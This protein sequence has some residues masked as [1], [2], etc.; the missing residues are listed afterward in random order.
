MGLTGKINI[1]FIGIYLTIIL[2]N[3][4]SASIDHLLSI[5]LNS[6]QSTTSYGVAHI[7]AALTVTNAELRAKALAE[8]D[9]TPEQFEQLQGFK[10]NSDNI[11]FS[12]F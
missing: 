7:L 10:F 6:I 9:M 2:N 4:V 5:D 12:N 1:Y 8:K 11:F 3:R